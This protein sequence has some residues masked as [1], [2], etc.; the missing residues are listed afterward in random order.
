MADCSHSGLTGIPSSLPETLD[1]LI[2][3]HNNVSYINQDLGNLKFLTE[4]STLNL[5]YN[6]LVNLSNGV[7]DVFSNNEN[8]KFLDIS[9]NNLTSLPENIKNI[10]S[11]EEIWI[12]G[13]HFKCS[14]DNIWMKRWILN[15]SHLVADYQKVQCQMPSNARIPITQMDPVKLGMFSRESCLFP[16][17]NFR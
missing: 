8:L 7:L 10:T 14:C 9:N 6:G 5:S 1:W 17:E 3:S 4:I 16:V 2:L 15:Q 12:S 11:L 13:N